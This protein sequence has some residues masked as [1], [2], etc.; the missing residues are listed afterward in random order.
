V[1]RGFGLLPQCVSSHRRGVLIG[2]GSQLVEYSVHA[3]VEAGGGESERFGRERRVIRYPMLNVVRKDACLS[4]EY[5]HGIWALS[6]QAW[7][8]I[9]LLS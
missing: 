8:L 6:D 3:Y 1:Y 5:R 2:T 4:D 9:E 7:R